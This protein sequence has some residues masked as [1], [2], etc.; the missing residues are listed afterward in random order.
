MKCKECDGPVTVGLSVGPFCSVECY[1]SAYARGEPL[2]VKLLPPPTAKVGTIVD[3]IDAR[4][5]SHA[6]LVLEIQPKGLLKLK[7]FRCARSDLIV[8]VGP[9]QWRKR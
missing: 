3:Y 9:S 5:M 4:G 7:V 2:V 6:A 8:E 1:S